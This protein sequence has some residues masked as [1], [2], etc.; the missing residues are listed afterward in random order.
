PSTLGAPDAKA[1]LLTAGHCISL[2]PYGIIRNQP[3]TAQVQFHFF[4]DTPQRRVTVRTR[5]TGWSTMKGVDLAL[6]ELSATLG[7][8]AAQGIRP[9]RLASFEPQAGRAVFWTGISSSPIPPEMQFLRR[10]QCTMGNKV[11]LIEGPWI[12]SGDLSNDC[13]DLYAGAS[14][15]PLFDEATGE[16]TGVI[17]TTTIL[18]FEQGPDFDCQINRPCVIGPKGPVMERDTSY[19]SPVQGISRCFDQ[20][21]SLD[22]GRPGCPLDPGFQLTV[23]SGANEVQPEADGRPTTWGARLSGS[24]SSY[25]Y[26]RFRAGEDTCGSLSGYSP[27]TLV[28]NAPVISDP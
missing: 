4:I 14:G 9:L 16:V 5:A 28:A 11:L 7:D 3:L 18:N 15:A 27:P 19:T 1:W 12:W 20:V 17:G 13:P 24:Q 6:V 10:G 8:L 25:S 21:N 26:K 22:P 2:E 23:Q